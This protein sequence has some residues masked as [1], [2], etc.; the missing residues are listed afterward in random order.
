MI[1][2]GKIHQIDAYMETQSK[3]NPDIQTMDNCLM[4]LARGGVIDAEEGVKFAKNPDKFRMKV[5]DLLMED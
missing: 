4:K 3:E 1:R 5:A 2:E